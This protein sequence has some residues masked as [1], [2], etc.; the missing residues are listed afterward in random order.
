MVWV[1]CAWIGVDDDRMEEM[2]EAE[3]RGKALEARVWRRS[4]RVVDG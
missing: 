2:A 1:K 3:A 4:I